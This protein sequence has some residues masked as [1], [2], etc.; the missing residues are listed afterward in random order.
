VYS[1]FVSMLPEVIAARVVSLP[2][3]P[4]FSFTS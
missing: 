4:Q 3:S 1:Q 2:F